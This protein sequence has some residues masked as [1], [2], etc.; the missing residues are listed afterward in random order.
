MNVTGDKSEN[1]LYSGNSVKEGNNTD[2]SQDFSGLVNDVHMLL[3]ENISV[4]YQTEDVVIQSLKYRPSVALLLNWIMNIPSFA[5]IV[6]LYTHD[7]KKIAIC[8]KLQ[9]EEF[10]WKCNAYK[11]SPNK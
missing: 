5:M 2:L 4:L 11:V 10:Q 7:Y 6:G 1:Y 9:T 8:N 3:S